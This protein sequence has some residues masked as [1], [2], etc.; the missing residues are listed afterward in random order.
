MYF[1]LQYLDCL[2]T[3]FRYTDTYSY[4]IANLLM[5]SVTYCYT[6]MVIGMT[7]PQNYFKCLST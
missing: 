2:L 5:K 7:G 6:K 4:C 3:V 1:Y